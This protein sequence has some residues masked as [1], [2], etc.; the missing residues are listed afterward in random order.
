MKLQTNGDLVGMVGSLPVRGAW[1]E[2]QP[3][4]DEN[5]PD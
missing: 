4:A 1:V 2:M 5:V 3:A